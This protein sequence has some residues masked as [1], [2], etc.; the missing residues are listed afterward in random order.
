MSRKG[1][2][3]SSAAIAVPKSVSSRTTTSGRHARMCSPT[4][5]MCR[6]APRREVLGE[7]AFGVLRVDGRQRRQVATGRSRA[8][9]AR[10]WAAP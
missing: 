4:A 5:T 6:R 7:L 10:W 9:A 2:L 8:A 3:A 1:R